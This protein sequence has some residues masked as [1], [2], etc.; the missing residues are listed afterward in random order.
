[1]HIDTMG[2]LKDLADHSFCMYDCVGAYS[3]CYLERPNAADGS[4][5]FYMRI[6]M[7]SLF[8]LSFTS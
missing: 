6:W 2:H 8:S 3:V 4:F 7:V 1:M 5:M